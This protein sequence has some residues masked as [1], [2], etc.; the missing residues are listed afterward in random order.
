MEEEFVPTL[1][2]YVAV[3]C[4]LAMPLAVTFI[5]AAQKYVT[6]HLELSS[7][8]YTFGYFFL[9]GFFLQIISIIKFCTSGGW[10]TRLWLFG[11]AGSFLNVLGGLVCVAAFS[12]GYP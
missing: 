7:E 4:S 1:P 12:T 5:Q 9:M 10:S 2:I 6:I 11:T 3:L 8:D